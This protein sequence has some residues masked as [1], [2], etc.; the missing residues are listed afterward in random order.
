MKKTTNN[1]NELLKKSF[2]GI[3]SSNLSVTTPLPYH[4]RYLGSYD[5]AF[6]CHIWTGNRVLIWD[7]FLNPNLALNPP[8]TWHLSFVSKT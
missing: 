8:V 7:E 4:L 2:V 6:K 5:I 1:T 3:W